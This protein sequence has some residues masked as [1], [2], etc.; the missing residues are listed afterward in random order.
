MGGLAAEERVDEMVTLTTEPGA[1]G[2]QPG[3]DLF[4]GTS[5]NA[6][7]LIEQAAMFDWYDGGGSTWPSWAW[8]RPTSTP[9]ST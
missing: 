7:A 6:E 1:V 8:R 9:T 5:R 2:G 4:F 3:A